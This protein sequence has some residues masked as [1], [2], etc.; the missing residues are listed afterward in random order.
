MYFV[1]TMDPAETSLLYLSSR[2]RVD[3]GGHNNAQF[4]IVTPNSV[5]TQSIVEVCPVQVSFP[6]LFDNVTADATF[7]VL[8]GGRSY[9]FGST[10]PLFEFELTNTA[11]GT[12]TGLI[13][14]DID[15]GTYTRQQVITRLQTALASVPNFE[16]TYNN[17]IVTFTYNNWDA[18][19]GQVFD[20]MD[21]T[22]T[23]HLSSVLYLSTSPVVY[24]LTGLTTLVNES[25]A[26]DHVFSVTIPKS[27]YTVSEL[28]SLLNTQATVGSGSQWFL[29]DDVL[30][31][32][33]G[34]S[35]FM[36][37][38]VTQTS[39]N[40]LSIVD[41]VDFYNSHALVT[42]YFK[43]GKLNLHPLSNVFVGVSNLAASSFTHG[44]TGHLY[45]VLCVV[46][47]GRYGYG[48]LVYWEPSDQ[49]LAR[50]NLPRATIHDRVKI[51][52]LD[53]N[54]N[55][56]YLD[57]HYHVDLI[58]KIYNSNHGHSTGRRR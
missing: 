34:T 14:V 27:H 8:Y 19:F 39:T 46:P 32:D 40:K 37:M 43:F 57:R 13:T 55:P 41:S 47:V 49:A 18:N 58:L 42:S 48:N 9:T 4:E 25:V 33:P 30:L 44:G 24:N 38:T 31:L 36:Q 53:D 3:P 45:D 12:S 16:F 20:T 52:L 7:S 21:F 50:L 23:T 35:N 17:G 54:M 6:N 5:H 2:Q 51:T 29:L 28:L 22:I 10:V 26:D 1:K 11:A 56:L 15:A